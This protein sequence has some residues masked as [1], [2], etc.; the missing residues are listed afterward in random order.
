MSDLYWVLSLLAILLS[1]L[2]LLIRS[3]EK[4]LSIREHEANKEAVARDIER[5]ENR[6]RHIEQTRPTTG[7]LQI[8]ADS[9]NKRLD[10]LRL[11]GRR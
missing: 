7:E 5:L 4:N 11:I 8:M 9:F 1:G 6:L 3:L 10:E 2:T